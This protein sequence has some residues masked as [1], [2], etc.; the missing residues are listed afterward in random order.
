[1]QGRMGSPIAPLVGALILIGQSAAPEAVVVRSPVG[2]VS[3][4]LWV[5][6]A[7]VI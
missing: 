5:G 2:Q 4:S 3:V 6:P 1:M 7:W